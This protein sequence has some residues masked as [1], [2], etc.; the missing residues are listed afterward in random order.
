MNS[1]DQ[2]EDCHDGNG[3]EAGEHQI[4]PSHTEDLKDHIEEHQRCEDRDREVD[5]EERDFKDGRG[6]P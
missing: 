6:T 2:I 3:Q 5:I 1:K 4:L